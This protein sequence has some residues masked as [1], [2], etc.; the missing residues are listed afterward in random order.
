VGKEKILLGHSNHY[1]MGFGKLA[2]E[3]IKNML[4]GWAM[5]RVQKR[6]TLDAEHSEDNIYYVSL[7]HPSFCT[8]STSTWQLPI[9]NNSVHVQLSTVLSPIPHFVSG[10][11]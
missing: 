4:K 9:L 10:D 7:Q 8:I 6:S 1:G 2:C 11:P 3:H 5:E